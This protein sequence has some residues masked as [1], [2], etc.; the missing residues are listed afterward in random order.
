M[1]PS[2]VRVARRPV[3][4]LLEPWRTRVLW[5]SLALNLFALPLLAIPHLWHR[6]PP[7]PPGFDA[8]L[9]RFARPLPGPDQVHLRGAMAAQR[10]WFDTA[11]QEVGD[12]RVAVADAIG[13][14]PYDSETTRRAFAALQD[15]LRQSSTRF[16]DGL[17]T[18]MAGLTPAGRT[19]LAD[20]M[21][22]RRP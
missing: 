6:P 9:D 21:R 7:G 12:K 19:A 17:L 5:A 4:R 2:T 22:R 1:T 11:R 14:E 10:P 3:L 20:S 18:A 15:A 16:D 8:L 13:R